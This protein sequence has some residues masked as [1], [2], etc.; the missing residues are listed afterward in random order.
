MKKN[1]VKINE[2]SLRKIVSESM[3]KVLNESPYDRNEKRV[4]DVMRNLL[5]QIKA[6]Y[7]RLYRI[8]STRGGMNT[9]S[10]AVK[11]AF[12]VVLDCKKA[13]EDNGY[14]LD[15]RAALP[16]DELPYGYENMEDY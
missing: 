6:A 8:S 2:N 10:D 15:T 3:K 11:R 1:I 12:N 9:E 16:T 14:N 5:L 7:E 13:F 4:D